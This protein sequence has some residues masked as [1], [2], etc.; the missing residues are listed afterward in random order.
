[1]F[2]FPVIVVKIIPSF[3][4]WLKFKCWLSIWIALQ[5][6]GYITFVLSFTKQVFQGKKSICLNWILCRHWANLFKIR[7]PCDHLNTSQ[8]LDILPKP[9]ISAT[10]W[11]LKSLHKM[12]K[13]DFLPVDGRVTFFPAIFLVIKQYSEDSSFVSISLKLHL[14]WLALVV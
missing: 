8:D 1:M 13:E 3:R 10:H 6:P 7:T 12:E 5:A 4:W 2:H 9:A 11:P 14:W